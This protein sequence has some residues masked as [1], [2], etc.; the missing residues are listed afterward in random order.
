MPD[1]P[2]GI[3][4]LFV[5]HAVFSNI[6]NY[7]EIIPYLDERQ[8]VYGLQAVGLDGLSKPYQELEKM[9]SHYIV[10][11]RNVQPNGPYLLAGLSFGGMLALELA[12]RFNEQGEKVLFVGMFDTIIP[13]E[14]VSLLGLKNVN[15][16]LV[17]KNSKSNSTDNQKQVKKTNRRLPAPDILRK[18]P[19]AWPDNRAMSVISH[20]INLPLCIT[21]NAMRKPKPQELR[22]WYLLYCHAKAIRSY[23]KKS[24]NLDLCL[25]RST[26]SNLQYRRDY[27]W[28]EL[29]NGNIE[30]VDV[31][32]NHGNV[33]LESPEFGKA[34][35]NCLHNK[36]QHMKN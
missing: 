5:L 35:Q 9:I 2:T 13:P 10:E 33:F 8:P 31:P 26:T 25:F 29:I 17:N 34:L 23:Q 15:E 14:I 21:Y 19:I 28:G 6:L 36:Y 22:G 20:L 12:H 11:I 18:I 24:Y 27:G 7:L 1:L 4:P 3:P 32:A 30:I 16:P